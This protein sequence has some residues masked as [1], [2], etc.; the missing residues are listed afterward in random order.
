MKIAEWLQ[1]NTWKDLE[2]KV[3]LEMRKIL[4]KGTSLYPHQLRPRGS[5]NR[6]SLIWVRSMTY[7]KKPLPRSRVEKSL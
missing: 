3:T 5:Y 7:C 2:N 1:V 6:W 4:Y